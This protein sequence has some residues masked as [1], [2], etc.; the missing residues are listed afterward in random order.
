MGPGT[1]VFLSLL[2]VAAVTVLIVILTKKSVV[3]P[4]ATD[5]ERMNN[6]CQMFHDDTEAL[7]DEDKAGCTDKD[8]KEKYKHNDHIKIGGTNTKKDTD[9][10]QHTYVRAYDDNDKKIMWSDLRDNLSVDMDSVC[11]VFHNETKYDES[12]EGCVDSD[13]SSKVYDTVLAGGTKKNTKGVSVKKW[14]SDE[15]VKFSDLK[16]ILFD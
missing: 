12:A 7:Y 15:S 10:Y 5:E 13:D 1:K 11:G 3:K 9:D 4:T 14:N 2:F 6:L 8:G 16:K